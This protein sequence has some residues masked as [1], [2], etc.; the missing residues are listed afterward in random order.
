MS[1]LCLCVVI[2]L[3][4]AACKQT[5]PPPP[6]ILPKEKIVEVLIEV[7]IAEQKANR[8]GIPQ[9]SA[10]MVFQVMKKEILSAADVKEPLFETS[11]NYYFAHPP[12]MEQIY[13]AVVDSLQLREQ[14]APQS[15]KK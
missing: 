1:T 3:G 12:E 6:D 7:Y 8:L 14:R 4:V 2:M 9:D 5:E 11:F 10:L 15:Q 13:T